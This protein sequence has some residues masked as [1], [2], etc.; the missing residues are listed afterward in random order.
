MGQPRTF[1][2]PAKPREG[3][4]KQ[5]DGDTNKHTSEGGIK[6]TIGPKY[7]PDHSTS[8]ER[9]RSQYVGK[10]VIC[11]T[12]MEAIATGQLGGGR[13]KQKDQDKTHNTSGEV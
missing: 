1:L 6:T 10:T 2:P 7:N 12:T 4:D 8:T 3:R 11:G 13:D 5:K 9:H